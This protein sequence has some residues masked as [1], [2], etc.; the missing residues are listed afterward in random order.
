[1]DFPESFIKELSYM[2]GIPVESFQKAIKERTDLYTFIAQEKG[3]SRA[4]VKH[5]LFYLFYSGVSNEC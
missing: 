4:E 5:K 1:M 2:T 3:M